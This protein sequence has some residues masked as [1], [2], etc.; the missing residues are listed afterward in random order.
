MSAINQ[1]AFMQCAFGDKIKRQ[2]I[3]LVE[4]RDDAV[5]VAAVAHWLDDMPPHLQKMADQPQFRM[6]FSCPQCAQMMLLTERREGRVQCPQCQQILELT[7]SAPSPSTAAVPPNN[8]T[9]APKR[10]RG[11]AP[12][13][14]EFRPIKRSGVPRSPSSS[15][16]SPPPQY[17]Y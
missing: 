4:R 8:N 16:P 5:K 17:D 11:Q 15:P 9:L 7:F 14:G 13:I 12:R 3:L 6:T 10:Y 2:C 1:L